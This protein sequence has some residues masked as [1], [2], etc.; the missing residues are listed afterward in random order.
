MIDLALRRTMAGPHLGQRLRQLRSI[1]RD[2]RDGDD[3]ARRS[4]AMQFDLE[5]RPGFGLRRRRLIDHGADDHDG[6]GGDEMA[7]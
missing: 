4:A 3:D 2:G 6:G 1:G 5:L 7:L